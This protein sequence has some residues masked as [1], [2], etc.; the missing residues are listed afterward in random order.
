MPVFESALGEAQVQ[1]VPAVMGGEDFS[2][3]GLTDP[4]I[5]SLIYW[6]GAV[7]PRT[8]QAFQSSGES[9]PSLHSPFFA[10]DAPLT[11]EAG[12][13][14]MT[15]AALELLGE[16]PAPDTASAAQSEAA[17]PLAAESAASSPVPAEATAAAQ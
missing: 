17:E 15:A 8:Y 2:E 9:L 6:M 11:I 13:K 1:A 3:Y 7:E 16:P 10:P 4:K 5:P 14:A 12:V